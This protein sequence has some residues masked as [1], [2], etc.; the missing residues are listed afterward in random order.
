MTYIEFPFDRIVELHVKKK[1]EPPPDGGPGPGEHHCGEFFEDRSFPPSDGKRVPLGP[2]EY[3]CG[4]PI[5]MTSFGLFFNPG[6]GRPAD[7]SIPYPYNDPNDIPMDNV[8]RYQIE[9]R[10]DTGSRNGG[11]TLQF[12]DGDILW[13]VQA[14][15]IGLG[16]TNRTNDPEFRVGIHYYPQP[17]P[18]NIGVSG[19]GGIAAI[20]QSLSHSVSGV[21]D[22][23]KGGDAALWF[24]STGELVYMWAF[25][26]PPP[27]NGW[28]D[29]DFFPTRLLTRI[30]GICRGAAPAPAPEPHT[31]K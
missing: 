4:P 17:H 20:G 10:V 14:S 15:G 8:I 16:Y 26:T 31:E 25:G 13:T 9:T 3:V 29:P 27:P 11:N 23:E 12:P 19:T 7:P 21:Y 2:P 5:W 30:T 1:D 18:P 28:R 22:V 24:M 6:F